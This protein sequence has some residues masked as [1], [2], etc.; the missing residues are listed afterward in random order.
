MFL[1]IYQDSQLL[2][3][4]LKAIEEEVFGMFCLTILSIC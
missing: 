2:I 1:D 4:K 3:V